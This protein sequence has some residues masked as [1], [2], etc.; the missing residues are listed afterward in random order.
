MDIKEGGTAGAEVIA[1]QNGLYTLSGSSGSAMSF[2]GIR[3]EDNYTALW[4]M[5]RNKY[6]GRLVDVLN[7]E[8]ELA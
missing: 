4:E 2:L 8:I 6:G 5:I 1:A 7:L 3:V